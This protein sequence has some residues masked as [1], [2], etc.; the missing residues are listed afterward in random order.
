MILFLLLVGGILQYFSL[1]FCAA[2]YT[3]LQCFN[4]SRLSFDIANPKIRYTLTLYSVRIIF[5]TSLKMHLIPI[6]FQY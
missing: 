3:H 5:M 4:G 1:Q 2:F 6:S